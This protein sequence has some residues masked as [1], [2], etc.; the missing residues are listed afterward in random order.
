MERSHK[1]DCKQHESID[2]ERFL[3]SANGGKKFDNVEA[4]EVGKYNVLLNACPAEVWD[5][6][7]TTWMESHEKFHDAFAAFPW[8]VMEVFSGPPTVAFSWRHWAN[9]TGTY[10]LHQGKGE[11]VEVY[12]FGIATVNDKLQLCDVDIYYNAENFINILRGKLDATLPQGGTDVV[13]PLG[14]LKGGCPHF[15]K[16]RKSQA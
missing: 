9:F 10:E 2:Q 6:E 8:E 11:F 4:D 13:G 1:L 15:E 7:N 14:G 16:L 3:L 12:G 5:S